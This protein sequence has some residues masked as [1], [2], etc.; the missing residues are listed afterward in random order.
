MTKFIEGREMPARLT[1]RRMSFTAVVTHP[2]EKQ[3]VLNGGGGLL[4]CVNRR[5]DNAGSGRELP[6][7]R[8]DCVGNTENPKEKDHHVS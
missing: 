3:H 7:S 5:P 8:Y 4:L 1:D 2:Y 6:V